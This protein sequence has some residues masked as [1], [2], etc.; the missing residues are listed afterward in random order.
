M[1][2]SQHRL[3]RAISLLG[4]LACTESS[5]NAGAASPTKTDSATTTTTTSI[6]SESAGWNAA[7]GRFIGYNTGDST[8][9]V[10]LPSFTDGRAGDTVF[11]ASTANGAK[12]ELF[13]G[14]GYAGSGTLAGLG[15]ASYAEGCFEFSRGYVD[16]AM[17]NHWSVALPAGT[18]KTLPVSF[19]SALRGADSAAL[20][21][22][23]LRAASML[24]TAADSEWR[25]A[26][27]TIDEG[28]RL[29]LP[30]GIALFA[31]VT[32]MLPGPQHYSQRY[33]FGVE[34]QQH[35]AGAA[36]DRVWQLSYVHPDR[37]NASDITASGLSSEDEVEV[38]AAIET[39]RDS[40]PVLILE[41]RGNEANG[42]AALGRRAPAH[43]RVVWN[44]PHEGG[45]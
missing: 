13:S 43:W 3:I 35:G 30:G 9:V 45:C 32:R 17:D 4:A 28:T 8:I 38:V 5:H 14:R 24:P 2:L 12:V 25:E 21:Q 26:P 40:M 7:F 16:G 19:L 11:D 34:S 6:S 44:G 1:L 10:L 20:A 29:N 18:A 22:D 36:G 15:K 42:Y 27:F 37:S 23:I 39:N 33:F 41:T 31:S